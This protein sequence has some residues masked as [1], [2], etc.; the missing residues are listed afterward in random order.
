LIDLPLVTLYMDRCSAIAD[1]T[2]I[3][4]LKTLKELMLPEGAAGI[5]GLR[6]LP[7][8]ERVSYKWQSGVGPDQTALEF[9]NS[10]DAL[11]EKQ[12]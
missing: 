1:V 6:A 11:R 8:L 10:R 9:W 7:G 2:P 4:G 3:A 12:P 5:D